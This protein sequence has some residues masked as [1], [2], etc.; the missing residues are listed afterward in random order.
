MY[1]NQQLIMLIYI[2]TYIT[3]DE[4]EFHKSQDKSIQKFLPNKK[5]IISIPISLPP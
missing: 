1:I 4:L 5:V 2:A 3:S